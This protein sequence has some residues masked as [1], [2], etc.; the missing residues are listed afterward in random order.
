MPAVGDNI[1][2][3]HLLAFPSASD[4]T[5]SAAELRSGRGLCP[6]H[7]QEPSA[8]VYSERLTVGLSATGSIGW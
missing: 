4:H 3:K 8:E 5:W 7:R 1:K 2:N 6:E